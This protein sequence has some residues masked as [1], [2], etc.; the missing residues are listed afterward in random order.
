[1]RSKGGDAFALRADVSVRTDC[2]QLVNGTVA[3]YRKL[4]IM[5]CNVGNDTIKPAE[6]LEEHKWD[7]I[8]NVDLNGYFNCA[9]LAARQ[10]LEQ[11]TGGSIIMSSSI[12][13]VVGIHGLVAY[14]A[15]SRY[16]SIGTNNSD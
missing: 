11:G 14:S 6:S 2:E 9:K 12:A 1:M 8:I 4:D 5:V 3:H 15:A 10:M 7:L 13:S 16:Q